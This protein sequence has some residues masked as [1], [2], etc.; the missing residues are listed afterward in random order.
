MEQ[1]T[2]YRAKG[3]EIGLVFLFKYD[4]NG[5]L[6]LFE[7]SEG[8]LNEVQMKWL[9]THFPA[10][11][12]RMQTL[13]M[14]DEKYTKVFTVEKSVA[15]LSFDALWKLY[16]HKIAKFHAEKAF[17]KLKEEAVIKCFLSIPLYKKYLAHSK[18]AQAHLATYINGRYYENEYPEALSTKNFNPLL[19]DFANLKTN[20]RS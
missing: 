12:S 2:T 16:D 14:K 3:K 20:R 15:D 5:N 19:Q 11:E 10:S 18:I 4:L 6:K 1:L 7:I 13:W 8:E 9:F 17:E